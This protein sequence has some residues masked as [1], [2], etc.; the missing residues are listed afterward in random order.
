MQN[1]SFLLTFLHWHPSGR[2]DEPLRGFGFNSR[3]RNRTRVHKD[4]ASTR[5]DAFMDARFMTAGI[6]DDRRSHKA[7]SVGAALGNQQKNL[8]TLALRRRW[9][10]LSEVV[11]MSCGLSARRY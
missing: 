3:R 4:L 6:R 9:A 1:P 2:W 7:R 8:G 10:T 5:T 11:G